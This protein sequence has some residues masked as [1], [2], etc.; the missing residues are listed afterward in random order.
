M[1][2]KNKGLCFRR[3]EKFHP[4]HQCSKKSLRLVIMGD[5]EDEGHAKVLALK[6]EQGSKV[7]G[8]ECKINRAIGC[9]GTRNDNTQDYEIGKKMEGGT[10]FSVKTFQ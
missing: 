6:V 8:L 10:H 9:C 2:R 5:E 3:G 7:E 4:M 1:D